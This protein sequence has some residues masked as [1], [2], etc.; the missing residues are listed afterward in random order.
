MTPQER[1]HA[2]LQAG[3]E[4]G[5]ALESI[6][7][8]AMMEAAV[9]GFGDGAE[10]ELSESACDDFREEVFTALCEEWPM[11]DAADIRENVDAGLRDQGFPLDR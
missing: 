3:R 9:E 1:K 4:Y 6:Y 7:A 10:D 2:D 5:Y 8:A 11:I